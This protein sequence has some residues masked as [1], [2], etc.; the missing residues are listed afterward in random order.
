MIGVIGVAPEGEAIGCGRIGDHGGNMDN[1]LI[2]EGVTLYFPVNTPG[3]LLQMGDLHAAMGDGEL[4]GAALEISGQVT[5]TVDVIKGKTLN[6]P[7]LETADRWYTTAA[8]S[9]YEETLKLA[10]TDMQDL[11]VDAYGWDHTDIDI[12]LSLDGH[13]EVN[14]GCDL[15]AMPISLRVGI[16]KQD[17]RPLIK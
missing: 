3:A 13:V 7:L 15:E 6:R 9:S 1:R 17:D 5:V 10:M 12:Y 11:V 14:Q 16:P 2:Q 8:R 4:D